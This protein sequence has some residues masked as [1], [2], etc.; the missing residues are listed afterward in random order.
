MVP[1]IKIRHTYTSLKFLVIGKKYWK[2][3]NKINRQLESISTFYLID[4]TLGFINLELYFSSKMQF[5]WL[6]R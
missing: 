3:L 2:T 4:I 5:N 6:I 1:Y